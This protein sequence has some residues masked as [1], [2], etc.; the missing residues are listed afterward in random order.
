MLADTH[1]TQELEQGVCWCA[2]V[3]QLSEEEGPHHTSLRDP[4]Q[5]MLLVA[6]NEEQCKVTGE[7]QLLQ[8]N[9]EDGNFGVEGLKLLGQ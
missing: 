4:R 5:G 9:I 1:L 7:W 3:G 6:P 2:V 8:D